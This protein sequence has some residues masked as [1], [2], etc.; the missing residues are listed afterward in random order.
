M[1]DSIKPLHGGGKESCSTYSHLQPVF[2]SS[3]QFN[4]NETFVLFIFGQHLKQ[5]LDEVIK[6]FSTK[7]F[8]LLSAIHKTTFY[9]NPSTCPLVYKAPHLFFQTGILRTAILRLQLPQPGFVVTKFPQKWR[10][11]GIENEILEKPV[12]C[13]CNKRCRKLEVGEKAKALSSGRNVKY[14]PSS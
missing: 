10:S 6:N 12:T 2:K 3:D 5:V 9:I 8:P 13:I 1:K 11:K 7:V 4:F 14:T